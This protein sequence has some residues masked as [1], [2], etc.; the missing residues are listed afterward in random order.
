MSRYLYLLRH[1]ES[2]EKQDGQ[3]DKEREL[4]PRGMRQALLIGTYLCKENTTFDAVLCSIADRAKATATFIAD[5]MKFESEQ[6]I[7][8][9]ALYD[10]STRTFFQYISQLNDQHHIVLCVGHNP[11]ISYL[12]ES[13]TKAEIGDMPPCGLAIIKFNVHSWKEVSQGN[14]ELQNYVYP[15]MLSEELRS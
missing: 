1:A 4:T 13:F 11:S 3:T 2:F 8:Q 10:A 5:A 15:G 7:E 14:G 12:A 6:I 9:E